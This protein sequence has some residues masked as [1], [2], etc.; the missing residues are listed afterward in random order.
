MGKMPKYD[1]SKVYGGV[2]KAYVP[3]SICVKKACSFKPR[4]SF[5]PSLPLGHPSAILTAGEALT[6]RVHLLLLYREVLQTQC[7]FLPWPESSA[8]DFAF[9]KR[10]YRT[11]VS[12]IS[13]FLHMMYMLH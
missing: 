3:M 2:T 7:V 1:G 10:L 12:S 9:G 11:A 5:L 6:P 13:P 4:Q 8:P